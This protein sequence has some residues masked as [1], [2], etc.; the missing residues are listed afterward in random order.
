MWERMDMPIVFMNVISLVHFI[1]GCAYLTSEGTL[2][3]V[4]LLY[5]VTANSMT[6][7]L[8]KCMSNMLPR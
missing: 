6:A 4:P 7:T 2:K 5:E 3:H 1:F 8:G